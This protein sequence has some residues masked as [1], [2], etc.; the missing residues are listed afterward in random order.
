MNRLKIT[1]MTTSQKTPSITSQSSLPLYLNWSRNK[2]FS[3][4]LHKYIEFTCRHWVSIDNS[5]VSLNVIWLHVDAT[6]NQK[7]ESLPVHDKLTSAVEMTA[8]KTNLSRCV[9]ISISLTL[10]HI[11]ML[12]CTLLKCHRNFV[13]RRTWSYMFRTLGDSVALWTW[14]RACIKIFC[15]WKNLR[16]LLIYIGN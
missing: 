5:S 15:N 11:I 8:V 13:C 16:F 14:P 4:T 10:W 12:F 1:K 7:Q 6:Q 3:V 9:P 2:Y